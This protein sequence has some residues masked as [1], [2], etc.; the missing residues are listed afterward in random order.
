MNGTGVIPDADGG[1]GLRLRV[2][3]LL[4]D[5][6]RLRRDHL[7]RLRLPVGDAAEVPLEQGTHGGGVEVP[8]EHAR[9]VVGRVVGPEVGVGLGLGDAGD[10][11][12]P[13]HHRP[14]V[15]TGLPEE[16]VEGLVVFP[17]RGGL[18]AHA[19]LFVNDVALGVELPEDGVHQAVRLQP[20]P[21][22]D[23]V[24]GQAHHVDGPVLARARVEPLRA[25]LRVDLGEVVL[26]LDRALLLHQLV[27][28]LV[29]LA[30]L[31]RL[32]L[33]LGDVVDLALALALAHH[34]HLFPHLRPDFLLLV[35]D[36]EVG[37]D[38]LGP[39]DARALEHHVLEEVADAGDPLALVH[40]AHVGHPAPDHRRRVVALEEQPAHPVRERELL[41]VDLRLLRRP[42]RQGQEG[43]EKK[44]GEAA[45]CGQIHVIGLQKRTS[46]RA[47]ECRITGGGQPVKASS[48]CSVT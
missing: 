45:G 16:G 38:V 30:I 14:L 7:R 32:V 15:R 39:D 33:R 11:R 41:H 26:D 35:D 44:E 2:E 48:R 9:Q 40:R 25:V 1:R 31:R 18:R 47:P 3:A 34:L 8:H 43:K 24:G 13:A 19:A 29:E 22:L 20:G 12:G 23:A 21:Q 4:A 17:E 27:E 6:R 37:V 5:L 46:A 36:A 42:R 28:L 10:V